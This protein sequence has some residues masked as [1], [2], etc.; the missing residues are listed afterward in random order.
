MYKLSVLIYNEN[1]ELFKDIGSIFESDGRHYTE[2]VSLNALDDKLQKEKYDLLICLLKDFNTDF[3]ESI[4]AIKNEYSNLFICVIS[5]SGYIENPAVDYYCSNE[6]LQSKT[7]LEEIVTNL[8]R[9]AEK[10]KN[11]IELS[12]MLLHDLRSPVQNIFGYME[13]LEQGVFGS[14][15]PGQKQILLNALSLGDTIVELMD[16][17]SQA[18][19]LEYR[20]LSFIKTA[21]SPKEVVDET[22][23]SLWVQADK[24]N[25]KLLSQVT[26]NL[27]DIDGDYLSIQRIFHNLINN[28]IKFT[29]QNG[30]V[31]ISSSENETKDG[32]EMITFR[33]NDSGPGIPPDELDTIFDKYY[34]VK[35]I[36]DRGKGQGLGLYVA[37]LLVTAHG[38]KIGAYN[39]REGGAALYFTI[40]VFNKIK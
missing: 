29:P 38:G 9:L 17:L 1:I 2:A 32:R 36:E 23:R 16:D 30:T 18:Y 39:N 12:A 3:Q 19:Q 27:P 13:L 35:H 22:L 4:A 34:R 20:G 33:I 15:S 40:P 31:R 6:S 21:V 11:Q 7:Y 14:I 5:E 26:S 28:A 24:K 37:K 8:T 10:Q 25:I